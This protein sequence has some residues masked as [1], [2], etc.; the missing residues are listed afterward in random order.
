MVIVEEVILR[1]GVSS[2][3]CIEIEVVNISKLKL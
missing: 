2:I 1:D 3:M